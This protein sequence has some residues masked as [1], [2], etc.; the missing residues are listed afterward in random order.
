[1]TN[2]VVIPAAVMIEAASD[3][4]QR[5]AKNSNP[6]GTEGRTAPTI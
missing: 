3:E 5:L 6:A 1:M 2:G 4:T